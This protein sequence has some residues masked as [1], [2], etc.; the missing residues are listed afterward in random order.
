[1]QSA[2]HRNPNHIA[3]LLREPRRGLRRLPPQSLV[4]SVDMIEFLDI[5]PQQTLR[6]CLFSTITWSNTSRLRLPPKRSN[7]SPKVK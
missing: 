3:W 4:G 2:Q 7:S 5:F 1:M 6:M